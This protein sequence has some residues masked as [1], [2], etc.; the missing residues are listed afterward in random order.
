MIKVV[1]LSLGLRSFRV[2]AVILGAALLFPASASGPRRPPAGAQ[3]V[4]AWNDL[5]MHCYD[6]DFSVLSMLP[7]FNVVHAQVV[8]RGDPPRLM[9]NAEAAATYRAEADASGSIN[10]TSRG[11]TNF[12]GYVQPLFGLT[13]R[14]PVDVGLLGAKMPGKANTPRPMATYDPVHRLFGALGIPITAVNDAGKKNPYNLMSVRAKNTAGLGLARLSAVVP[15]SD[16]MSCG[17]CHMSGQVA[18]RRGGVVWSNDKNPD[19]Q[20]RKNILILHD[21]VKGTRLF[22]KQ[23]VLCASCH[24]SR[25]LDLKG[26]GPQTKRPFL[27]RA[28]HGF[29]F[30]KIV[31]DPKGT[32]TCFYCHPG[33]TT[34]CLR[35][36]MA[37]GGLGCVDCHGNMYAVARSPRQP[38]AEEPKCQS[39]H[40][41]DAV[42]HLGATIR[43]L[44]AYDGGNPKY[45]TPRIAVNKRFAEE[46][47]TTLYRNSYG[48]GGLAC[49]ACHGSPHA[50]WPTGQANDNLA[51]AALQGFTGKIIDCAVCHTNP[52]RTVSG[53]HGLHNVNASIWWNDG[54]SGFYEASPASCKACHGTTLDGTELS[55]VPTARSF[56]VEDKT[57]SLRAGTSVG[58]ILCHEKPG[59]GD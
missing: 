4:F 21:A 43:L 52:A 12:W 41:G 40:T 33:T 11:K 56:A 53:P 48:H 35:G 50:E 47:D 27:S 3:A 28:I 58:C 34:Q 16:E 10:T 24:Y 59:S 42:S 51:A 6:S 8:L 20:F 18:A 37:I 30:S 23:P 19:L 25:A 9:T 49:E 55:R 5:G 46:A 38:W 7:L 22:H 17:T 26:Q 39:C 29:H 54:H 31:Q 57:V 32:K 44:T 2:P 13:A 45:A 1:R 36:I 14:P 15:A